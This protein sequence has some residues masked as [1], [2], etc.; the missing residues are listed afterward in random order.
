MELTQRQAQAIDQFGNDLTVSASAGAGKTRVLIERITKEIL[1]GK[2]D[3]DRILAMTFTSAAAEEMKKRLHQSLVTAS[4]EHPDDQRIKEQLLLLPAADVSTIHSFC[5][6]IIQNYSYLLGWDPSRYNNVLDQNSLKVLKQEA[7]FNTLKAHLDDPEMIDLSEKYET[8]LITFSTLTTLIIKLD[9]FMSIQAD[10]EAWVKNTLTYYQPVDSLAQLP[11]DF[12]QY[13]FGYYLNMI[14]DLVVTINAFLDYVSTGEKPE[15]LNNLYQP[16]LDGLALASKA[17]VANDY[18]ELTQIMRVIKIGRD[19]GKNKVLGV[20]EDIPYDNYKKIIRDILKECQD[21]PDEQAAIKSLAQQKDTVAYLIKLADQYHKEFINLKELNNG[22]DFADM[23]EAALG[24]LKLPFVSAE[25]KEHYQ[26]ILVDEYQ[27]SNNLQETLIKTICDHNV[28]RVGDTKQSIYGFRN[29]KPELMQ[30]LLDHPSKENQVITLD[31]NFRSTDTIIEFNNRLYQKLMSLEGFEGRFSDDDIVSYGIESQKENNTPIDLEAFEYDTTEGMNKEGRLVNECNFILNKIQE[32][33]D[34]SDLTHWKDYV[35]LV[36]NNNIKSI[37]EPLFKQAKIPYF[38]VSP[39]G[40]YV[41]N[42]VSTILSWLRL[43]SDQNDDL[44]LIGIL[45]SA[46]YSLTDESLANLKIAKGNDGYFNYLKKTGNPFIKDYE[47]MLKARDGNITTLLSKLFAL[48]DYHDLHTTSWERDNLDLMYQQ[49]IAADNQNLNFEEFLSLLNTNEQYDAPTAV[50][51]DNDA[52]VVKVMTVHNSKGLEFK[53][54]FYLTNAV[55]S[56]HN[57]AFYNFDDKLGLALE[58]VRLPYHYA[59][60]GVITQAIRFK[61]REEELK[62]EI[63]VMYVATTRAQKRLTI[64]GYYDTPTNRSFFLSG[65]Q[66]KNISGKMY[67]GMNLIVKALQSKPECPR[68]LYNLHVHDK[69]EVLK[70]RN[71]KVVE[72]EYEDRK[73]TKPL[74]KVTTST[75]SSLEEHFIAP[76]AVN[77]SDKAQRGT[78]LHKAFELLDYPTYQKND[79]TKL[80]LGLAT[81]DIDKID[82][83][84]THPKF[85]LLRDKEIH[86]EYPFFIKIDGSIVHGVMDLVAIGDKEIILVD[87]KS[88]QNTNETKLLERYTVQLQQYSKVLS[89]SYP[90]KKV[91]AYLYS[92]ENAQWVKVDQA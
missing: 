67:G 33:K 50:A 92:I 87:F 44:S 26:A 2:I 78:I 28:F 16:V 40:Y 61:K 59:Y 43:L 51:A 76:I 39:A 29:A 9:E 46:Y 31:K 10:R 30:K 27:D 69:E 75:P 6:K 7:A 90:G 73:Y 86:Q 21:I 37:L 36:R 45:R 3:I 57:T 81:E 74:V 12:K 79:L 58:D 19:P 71:E 89:Q 54:V 60:T 49:G 85:E 11:D 22:I 65:N 18:R 8:D 66:F 84:F 41:D 80:D 32:L 53:H 56:N 20:T 23:E 88:D 82:K 1:S 77:Q 63:R 14:K 13:Y 72:T 52:D 15:L 48:N 24:L 83:F 47:K 4:K 17:L 55:L 62:E 34:T 91:T 64:V 35:I 68:T 5:L 38:F 25:L 42:A 70:V